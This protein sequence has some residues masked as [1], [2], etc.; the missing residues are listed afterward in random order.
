[1][2][3]G[4]YRIAIFYSLYSV[5]DLTLWLPEANNHFELKRIEKCLRCFLNQ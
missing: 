3:I 4:L 2:Q 1:M 5:V